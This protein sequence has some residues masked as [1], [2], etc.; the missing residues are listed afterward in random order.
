MLFPVGSVVFLKFL[1]LASSRCDASK[2]HDAIAPSPAFVIYYLRNALLNQSGE[3]VSGP[4]VGTL[5]LNV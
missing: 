3:N 5:T 1:V 2:R 4:C